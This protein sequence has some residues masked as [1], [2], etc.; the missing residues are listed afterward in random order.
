M[1]T[2]L[3]PPVD[4][5]TRREFLTGGLT[6]AALLATGCAEPAPVTSPQTRTVT[7]PGGPVE[8]P[9]RAQRVA[10][11]RYLA[12]TAQDLAVPLVARSSYLPSWKADDPAF[13]A[14]PEGDGAGWAPQVELLASLRPDLILAVEENIATVRDALVR[15]APVVAVPNAFA[16][17][18]RPLTELVAAATGVPSPA[19]DL[20][21]LEARA[22]DVG[23]RRPAGLRTLAVIR[24][25]GDGQFRVYNADSFSGQ[26]AR[27]A[28]WELQQLGPEPS[29]TMVSLER[30]GDL[31]AD[32]L[33][34][35]S[36]GEDQ[37]QLLT[38]LTTHPLWA[39]LPAVRAGRA[40]PVAEH[41]I[42]LDLESVRLT[43]DD[44][45]RVA[46][47]AR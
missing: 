6:L 15:I 38:A 4:D 12:E 1:P 11:L 20:T 43:L 28:G 16:T 32:V 36:V 45:D 13:R 26:L 25:M 10:A 17:G 7:T 9:E 30:L 42:G 44:L 5:G 41:W 2:L 23:R 14:L 34:L 35:W 39:G 47:R 3:A 22:A 18:W 29:V 46:E 40:F 8:V 27:L 33:V 19:A 21:A 37:Q 24:P 31:T